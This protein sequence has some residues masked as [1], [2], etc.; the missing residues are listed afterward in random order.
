[1]KGNTDNGRQER[2]EKLMGVINVKRTKTGC[3]G[4]KNQSVIMALS[5]H[6]VSINQSITE[7]C[8]RKRKRKGKERQR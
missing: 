3:I 4:M 7:G 8:Y 1:M 2:K 5:S 6:V